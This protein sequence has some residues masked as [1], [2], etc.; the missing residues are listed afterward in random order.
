MTPDIDYRELL[1]KYIRHVCESEGITFIEGIG[2]RGRDDQLWL[3]PFSEQEAIE[4]RK[5][6]DELF[7][8]TKKS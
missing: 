8:P 3:G 1:K 7:R 5:L 6:G 4:L 2:E